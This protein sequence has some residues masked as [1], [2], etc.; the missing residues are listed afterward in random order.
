MKYEFWINGFKAAYVET[1]GVYTALQFI[2]SA[3]TSAQTEVYAGNTD[4]TATLSA[5]ATPTLGDVIAHSTV[6]LGITENSTGGYTYTYPA[7]MTGGGAVKTPAS[8]SSYQLFHSFDGT[9][10]VAV[11]PMYGSNGEI[12]PIAT[13]KGTFVCTSGGAITVANANY[14]ITSDVI[15]TTNTPGGTQTYVP[16]I[17]AAVNG[18]VQRGHERRQ[19]PALTMNRL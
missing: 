2:G 14:L 15:I 18:V 9:H 3:Y 6:T 8:T 7:N 17:T 11:S 16:N 5:N 19:I 13:R 1:A 4:N 10:L 12:L